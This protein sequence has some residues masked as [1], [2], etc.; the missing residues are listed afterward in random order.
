[1]QSSDTDTIGFLMIL[2]IIIS[3]VGFLMTLLDY[4]DKESNEDD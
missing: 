1:M 4:I 2:I 3:T